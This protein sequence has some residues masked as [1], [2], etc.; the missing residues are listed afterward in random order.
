[1]RY[2]EVRLIVKN[3]AIDILNNLTEK[4]NN[5]TIQ[6]I[7]KSADINKSYGD[8]FYIG[9]NYIDEPTAE[10]IENSMFEL[11][12]QDISY[13]L[14]IIGEYDEEIEEYHHTSLNDEEKS[15]P[16]PSVIRTFDEKD[17]EE[18]LNGYSNYINKTTNKEME[19]Y[20]HSI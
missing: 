16:Y 2:R 11:E 13:R 3:N 12:E 15:I 7:I 10:L 5:E 6:D 20:E 18:Q 9:W 1:M 19:D 4:I 17:M 8:I 14:T